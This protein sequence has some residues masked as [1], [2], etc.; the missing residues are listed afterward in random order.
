MVPTLEQDISSLKQ[1][2]LEKS[3]RF[4]DFGL[5]SF[6]RTDVYV[7]AKLTTC[8]ARWVSVIG[9]VFLARLSARDWCPVAVG[10]LTIGADPI[11]MA[12]ASESTRAGQPV[13]A[14]IVRKEAKK[15]GR[16]RSIE[17]IEYTSGIPVVIIDDVCTRGEST[18]M[19]IDKAIAAEMNV[20]GAICLV[21]RQMGADKLI[22]EKFGVQLEKIFT[23]SELRRSQSEVQRITEA[24][25]AGI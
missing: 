5:A 15:H 25:D 10:G 7:D 20:I 2:L 19:A 4:G 11:A 13:D 6:D 22:A 8:S 16:Q 1:A 14:F 17:G 12:I 21:D 9:R 3:I 24:A 18:A 23:L